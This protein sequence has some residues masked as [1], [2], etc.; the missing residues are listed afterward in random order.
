ME[1]RVHAAVDISAASRGQASLDGLSL[2]VA[3]PWQAGDRVREP[4]GL[5]SRPCRGLVAA[6]VRMSLWNRGMRRK[7]A[8]GGR[9]SRAA[10]RESPKARQSP[11]ARTHRH[12]STCIMDTLLR[13]RTVVASPYGFDLARAVTAVTFSARSS[14]GTGRQIDTR[15]PH[16]IYASQPEVTGGKCRVHPSLVRR[17][18]SALR[19]TLFGLSI[20]PP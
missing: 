3:P 14:F 13:R 9:S 1:S 19:A 10:A 17:T 20:F 15:Q 7:H 5:L 2:A 18:R 4:Q 6:Q 16:A 12:K 11:R 8:C